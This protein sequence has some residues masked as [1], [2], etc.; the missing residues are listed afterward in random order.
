MLA[1]LGAIVAAIVLHPALAITLAAGGAVLSE[2]PR[3]HFAGSRVA[4]HLL[5]V[6]AS[7]YW[8]RT[9]QEIAW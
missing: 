8:S 4:Y 5:I 2:P 1:I 3:A 9:L 6:R 7:T